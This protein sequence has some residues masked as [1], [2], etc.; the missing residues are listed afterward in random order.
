MTDD[1]R[2]MTGVGRRTTDDGRRATDEKAREFHKDR[3]ALFVVSRVRMGNIEGPP[4]GSG[5]HVHNVLFV[6][7]KKTL[8]N[9]GPTGHGHHKLKHNNVQPRNK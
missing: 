2:R 7:R 5:D 1:G 6:R 4:A 8:S 9:I 3:G